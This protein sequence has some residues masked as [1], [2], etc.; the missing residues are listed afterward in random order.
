[1]AERAAR[2]AGAAALRLHGGRVERA[3]KAS[4]TDV[5]TAADHAAEAAALAALAAHRPADG[6]LTEEGVERPGGR[7]WIVDALDGSMNFSAGLRGWCSAVAL[8]EDGRTL[9]TAVCDPTG[10]E[11]FSAAAGEGCRLNGAPVHAAPSPPLDAALVATFVDPRRLALPGVRLATQALL[12]RVGSLRVTGSGS[13]E[14][15]WVAAGR[16]HAW[17][18]ADPEPW[19]WL[20]GA[21]LVE[22]AGGATA[23][24]EAGVTWN[25]A[26]G[27]ALLEHLAGVIRGPASRNDR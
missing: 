11:L 20:P 13:L 15:A 9:A 25:L 12:D 19:D 27:D 8:V 18:Q 21:L 1:M 3:Q 26:G 17:I 2:A 22:E 24:L 5:V 10:A 14:L 23:R 4:P 16:L 7:R 6:V